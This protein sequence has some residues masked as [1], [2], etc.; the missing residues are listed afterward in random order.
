MSDPQTVP[1]PT[2]PAPEHDGRIVLQGATTIAG[3]VVSTIAGLAAK[4]V[5]G[6]HAL[7]GG[8]ARALGPVRERVPGG[9]TDH[10]RG[11]STEVGPREATVAVELVAEHGVPLAALAEAVRRNVV[12]A[13]DRMTGLQVTVVDVEITDLFLPGD[14]VPSDDDAL[15]DDVLPADAR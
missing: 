6:V 3:D 11:V 10:G 14:D 2:R 15:P 4:E 8:A 9:R 12:F 7:G 5:P 13:V 1:A